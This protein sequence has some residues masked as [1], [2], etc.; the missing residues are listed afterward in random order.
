MHDE[1]NDL[2]EYKQAFA[3]KTK[4]RTLADAMKN[5]DVVIG[6]SG[7][8]VID[9]DMVKSMAAKPVVFALSNP[10]PEISPKDALAARDDLIMATGRSDYPNQ[11]NN[12][13]GFPFIF[14]GAL[15]VRA[16]SINQ[17]MQIAAVYALRDLAREPVPQSVLE[18]YNVSEMT[19]GKDYIIPK[20][21]DPRLM[22]NVPPRVAKAA[23]DTGVAQKPYPAHYPPL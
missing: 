3:V 22:D 14:R 8:N 21:V 16:K 17:E 19:F 9:T 11:V 18:A 15:D 1:R 13:L 12:V 2:N 20:P 10:D 23:V 4:D 5:A 7:P 6:V